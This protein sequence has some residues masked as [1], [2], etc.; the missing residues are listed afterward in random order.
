[1]MGWKI[2][3][4]ESVKR[5]AGSAVADLPRVDA[6]SLILPPGLSPLRFVEQTDLLGRSAPAI[7]LHTTITMKFAS[8]QA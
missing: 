4:F 1:M 8:T 5:R 2:V 7:L 6:A 3:L